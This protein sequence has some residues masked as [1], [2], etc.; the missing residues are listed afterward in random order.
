M[1]MCLPPRRRRT[2]C[3]CGERERGREIERAKERER[4]RRRG[5]KRET[6]AWRMERGEIEI[7]GYLYRELVELYSNAMIEE[8]VFFLPI[9]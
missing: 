5:E 2:R 1:K 7:E 4:E 6:D 3:T 9:T 8:R